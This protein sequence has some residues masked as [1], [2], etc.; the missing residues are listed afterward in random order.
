MRRICFSADRDDLAEEGRLGLDESIEEILEA[1]QSLADILLIL[2]SVSMKSR[3][4]SVCLDA[5]LFR[6]IER[7]VEMILLRDYDDAISLEDLLGAV[8]AFVGR[9]ARVIG[10]DVASVD[11][12]LLSLSEHMVDLVIDL[13]AVVSRHQKLIRCLSLSFPHMKSKPAAV[14]LSIYTNSIF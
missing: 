6:D 5:E 13:S 8:D 11:P 2:C 9:E 12:V 1:S 7:A 3:A 10:E 14:P 4:N